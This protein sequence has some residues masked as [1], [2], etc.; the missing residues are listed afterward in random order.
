MELFG[1]VWIPAAMF[2]RVS[3]R[4]RL[5]SSTGLQS[6]PGL[7]GAAKCRD[8]NRLN[9]TSADLGLEI[10][11]PHVECFGNE[12]KCLCLVVNVEA[13]IIRDGGTT[14]ENRCIAQKEDLVC[15]V[16]GG[17]SAAPKK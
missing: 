16:E 13:V 8:A 1:L 3:A 12:T 17:K 14:K 6:H 9:N 15:D 7:R 10:K 5:I 4:Q 11:S 2:L